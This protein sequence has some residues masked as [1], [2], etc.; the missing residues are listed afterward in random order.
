M[1]YFTFMFTGH[2]YVF[3]TDGENV[4]WLHVNQSPVLSP[5]KH[6]QII[7]DMKVDKV[8]LKYLKLQGY[9]L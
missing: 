5:F 7:S 9:I 2:R 8:S 6:A 4:V 1:G 3:T